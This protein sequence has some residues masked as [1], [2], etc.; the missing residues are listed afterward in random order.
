MNGA[1]VRI[2]TA[3]ADTADLALFGDWALVSGVPC[4]HVELPH[5]W[6]TT[7]RVLALSTLPSAETFANVAAWLEARSPQ[8]TLMIRAKDEP[9]VDGFRRWDVMPVLV[10]RSQPASHPRPPVEIGPARD[11]EE[12]LVPYGAELA[13][14]VTDAHL[15]AEHMHH[16]VARVD[17]EPVGCARV[18]LMAGTAYVGAITVLPAWR[19]NG[20]GA[21]LTIASGELAARYSDLVW[22]HCT[23]ASRALYERLGYSHVDDHVLLVRADLEPDGA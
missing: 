16:L 13:P 23:P 6:A 15:A 10:L 11:C 14:L 21:A 7:G 17:G 4:L 12:F 18:R 5:A 22:L 1:A 8:W 19:G 2:A 20:L 3:H 9:K